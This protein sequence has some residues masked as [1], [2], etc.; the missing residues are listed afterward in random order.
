[1]EHSFNK[2]KVIIFVHNISKNM[3]K[4]GK[5]ILWMLIV[6]S[7][8]V[9]AQVTA[10]TI[11]GQKI[12]QIED[13]SWE[14]VIE[15]PLEDELVHSDL[16]QPKPNTSLHQAE[17]DRLLDKAEELERSYFAGYYRT[18]LNKSKCQAAIAKAQTDSDKSKAKQLKP[19]LSKLKKLLIKDEKLYVNMGKNVL[20]I[21]NITNLKPKKQKAEINDLS[22]KLG[23]EDIQMNRQEGLMGATTETKTE[24]KPKEA[25]LD[26]QYAMRQE[27]GH[28]KYIELAPLPFFTY[29]STQLKPYFKDKELMETKAALVQKGKKTY[30]KLIISIISRDAAK[31]YGYI[32]KGNLLRISFINGRNISLYSEQDARSEIENYTGHAI[33]TAMYSLTNDDVSILKKMPIDTVGL[34]W[35]SGIEMYDI[36]NVDSLL[37][38]FNCLQSIK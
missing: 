19:I 31:N 37:Q 1:M 2:L 23:L 28:L 10:T 13:G 3:M 4:S 14:K 33:Y 27:E 26:C 8:N 35:S 7:S 25:V 11:S 38:L 32:P 21:K 9:T 16:N 22:R 6:Y 36:Y 12:I 15:I 20:A 29:T 18:E 34:L 17:I 5:W 24:I 30:L